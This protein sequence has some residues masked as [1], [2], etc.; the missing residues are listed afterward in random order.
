MDASKLDGT[1][2]MRP[3]CF[4][5]KSNRSDVVGGPRTT[6]TQ[7]DCRGQQGGNTV[8][9]LLATLAVI[10]MG[11]AL[12]PLAQSPAAAAVNWDQTPQCQWGVV[13]G[14]L[15][16]G[17]W[18]YWSN[19][20]ATSPSGVK[21]AQAPQI[22]T[23][24]SL[25]PNVAEARIVTGQ[26]SAGPTSLQIAT[27]SPGA[28]QVCYT[29]QPR[30]WAPNDSRFCIDIEVGTE[31]EP[32]C[33][34][35]TKTVD[36]YSV[37]TGHRHVGCPALSA[38]GSI[39][40]SGRLM[41]VTR[42]VSSNQ[43]I[44]RV[45][46][47]PPPWDPAGTPGA[48]FQP[49]GVGKA[50]IC[51][52]WTPLPGIVWDGGPSCF[53]NTFHPLTKNIYSLPKSDNEA[54]CNFD[55][56]ASTAHLQMSCFTRL[57]PDIG[58]FVSTSDSNVVELKQYPDWST[59]IAVG[60]GKSTVCIA[61]TDG[62]R[63]IDVTSYEPSEDVMAKSL[64]YPGKTPAPASGTPAPSADQPNGGAAAT[65]SPS[66]GTTTGPTPTIVFERKGVDVSAPKVGVGGT[67]ALRTN[68]RPRTSIQVVTTAWD[69]A[70]KKNKVV[71]RKTARLDGFGDAK[72]AVRLAAGQRVTVSTSSGTRLAAI[73]T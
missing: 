39:D 11:A 50:A 22:L 34:V 25:N 73:R 31:Q 4:T 14:P 35:Q 41:P 57:T 3:R 54:K 29:I 44:M 27:V 15:K 8:R 21:E 61:R 38:T 62:E 58:K 28:T 37:S 72:V 23:V 19:G 71:S 13:A 17:C 33:A 53:I 56:S 30:T 40:A 9:R 16:A 51:Y 55:A 48:V 52:W 64:A 47:V 36:G 18:T 59:M 46:A 26:N 43:G 63:C 12:L 70:T 68:L 2:C 60:V 69:P 7:A 5:R 24:E 32:V 6:L 45:T 65:P 42:A 20:P 1:S 67:L 10:M 49:S 66:T